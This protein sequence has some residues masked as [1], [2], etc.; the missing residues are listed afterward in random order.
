MKLLKSSI[1][2]LFNICVISGCAT[3]SSPKYSG[4]TS[5][6]ITKFL[7]TWQGTGS[8]SFGDGR[9]YI[10]IIKPISNSQVNID[11][12][13]TGK[14]IYHTNAIGTLFG[15]TLKWEV[16]TSSCSAKMASNDSIL[17]ES[18]NFF[19]SAESLM[20]RSNN[21]DSITTP[22]NAIVANNNTQSKYQDA[23][24]CVA[25]DHTT[26]LG[27]SVF[28]N[29]CGSKIEMKWFDEGS[30]STGCATAIP[31]NGTSENTG[32]KGRIKY[33]ACVYPGLPV[34][35]GFGSADCR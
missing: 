10:L 14:T 22:T 8:N 6:D 35:N 26:G 29:T 9:N 3:L 23:T 24:H 4:T 21:Y 5:I 28:R 15:D 20:Q 31:A 12:T 2:I 16:A 34:W 11:F 17:Y 25:Y 1:F 32:I 13:L 33:V 30:C 19:S 18:H 27:F 7:G